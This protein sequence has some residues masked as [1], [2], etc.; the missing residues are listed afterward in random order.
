MTHPMNADG[1]PDLFSGMEF[2]IEDMDMD[3]WNEFQYALKSEY[4]LAIVK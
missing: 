2:H 3:T 4:S 1:T